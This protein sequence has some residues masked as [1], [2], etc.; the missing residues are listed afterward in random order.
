MKSRQ[1]LKAGYIA[2]SAV[3]WIVGSIAFGLFGI[4]PAIQGLW[5][6]DLCGIPLIVGSVSWLALFY[7]GAWLKGKHADGQK[8]EEA[9]KETINA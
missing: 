3:G 5:T 9:T 4:I 6:W 2:V 7:L 8:A 1:V